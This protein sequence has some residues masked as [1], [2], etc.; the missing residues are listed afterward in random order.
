MPRKR[1]STLGPFP[2]TVRW[3]GLAARFVGPGDATADRMLLELKAI[4]EKLA[5][6]SSTIRAATFL[7]SLPICSRFGDPNSALKKHYKIDL[8]KDPD[9]DQLEKSLDKFI[10]KASY[11][12]TAC[13]HAIEG[14]LQRSKAPERL[15]A[16]DP[17]APWRAADGSAFSDLGREFF[18]HLNRIYFSEAL[19]TA[20]PAVD[21]FA[22]EMS[23]ITRT[24]LARWFNACARNQIPELGSIQWYLGHCL[25]KLD[26]ELSRELSNWVEEPRVWK[27]R[28]PRLLDLAS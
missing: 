1:K 22:E 10:V 18:T 4:Y 17:W 26:L 24:F 28:Q 21:L 20:D 13:L 3:S 15:F 25:G 14:W 5:V 27:S 9:L 6:D 2:K 12:K 8:P 7:T 16:P 11:A 23:L 19:G